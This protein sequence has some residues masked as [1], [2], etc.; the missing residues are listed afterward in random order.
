M[1]EQGLADEYEL[2]QFIMSYRET[3]EQEAHE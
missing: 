3:I 2:E 1:F